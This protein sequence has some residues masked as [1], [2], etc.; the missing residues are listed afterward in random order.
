MSELTS[1]RSPILYLL[2]CAA[3][4]A[5]QTREVVPLLQA[6]GWNVCIIVTPQASR[7]VDIEGLAKLSGHLDAGHARDL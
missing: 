5:Q 6:E 7:W 3:P 4:P 2:V 1:P